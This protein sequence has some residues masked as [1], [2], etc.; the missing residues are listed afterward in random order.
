MTT[1]NELLK[2]CPDIRV[3]MTASDLKEFARYVID[4]YAERGDR[5]RAE[6]ETPPPGREEVCER[7]NIT[8]STLHSWIKRGTVRPTHIGGRVLFPISEITRAEA[9]GV[10][11]SKRR[12]VWKNTSRH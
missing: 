9:E 2:E 6:T 5:K 7:W 1:I 8:K 4:E 11:K 10:G 12:T 3:T